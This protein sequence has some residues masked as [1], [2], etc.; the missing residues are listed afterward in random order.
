MRALVHH[1]PVIGCWRVPAVLPRCVRPRH[2]VPSG[3]K[4]V[5]ECTAPIG[6]SHRCEGQT[7]GPSVRP[8]SRQRGHVEGARGGAP[9]VPVATA[10]AVMIAISLSFRPTA[11]RW[12]P[13]GAVSGTRDGIHANRSSEL[14]VSRGT[15]DMALITP[16][17]GQV[18]RRL[19]TIGSSQSPPDPTHARGSC[20]FRS[21]Q[22]ECLE[23]SETP[24][25]PVPLTIGQVTDGRELT[26]GR[27]WNSPGKWSVWSGITPTVPGPSARV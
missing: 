20:G 2:V 11:L 6:V 3:R 26:T 5:V 9:T 22:P 15:L 24:R 13:F 17:G 10:V 19:L 21:L 14:V 23:S 27:G 12:R 8:M 16:G 18:H 25:F 1:L 4:R 7:Y